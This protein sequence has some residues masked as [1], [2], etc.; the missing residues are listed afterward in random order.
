MST[1]L[2]GFIAFWACAFTSLTVSAAWE[3]HSFEN[4]FGVLP[5]HVYSPNN[6]NSPPQRILLALHGCT[7]GG[8]EF[9]ENARLVELANRHN[10]LIIAPE[11]TSDR[12]AF[13]CWN[14]FKPENQDR[15]SGE[16][17]MF[18]GMLETVRS[19]RNIPSLPTYVIGFSAGA[20]MAVTM[21]SCYPD[22]FSGA[23][24]AAGMQF[25]AA[26]SITSGLLAMSQGSIV[27]PAESATAA[28]ACAGGNPPLARPL[29]TIHGTSDSTV[30]PVNSENISTQV[31]GIFDFIDDGE[32]NSSIPNEPSSVE[33][34]STDQGVQYQLFR[35]E[36]SNQIIVWSLNVNGMGHSWTGGNS[37]PYMEPNGPDASSFIQLFMVS[38]D[39]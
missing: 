14:W 17:S 34:G 36:H 27:D 38:V 7:L 21:N 29:L 33:S 20:A 12:N 16:P 5:Y 13:L 39:N 30:N 2:F 22:V 6:H 3:S 25:K 35:T 24:A 32:V 31:R 15:A 11:Q 4:E 23:V 26:S 10:Y 19:K 9:S 37:G 1:R 18:M 8:I 28:I